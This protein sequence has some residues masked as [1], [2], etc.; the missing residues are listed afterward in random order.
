[1]NHGGEIS[2]KSTLHEGTEVVMAF[3]QTG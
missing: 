1:V 3:P 2:V